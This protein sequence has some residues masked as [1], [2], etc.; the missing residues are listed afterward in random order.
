MNIKD[1]LLTFNKYRWLVNIVER[2]TGVRNV[3]LKTCWSMRC[4]I[5]L[6]KYFVSIYLE[7]EATEKGIILGILNNKNKDKAMW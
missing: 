3:T 2:S 5:G 7:P 6:M 4:V 1:G